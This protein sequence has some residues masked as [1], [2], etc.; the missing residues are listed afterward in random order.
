MKGILQ[1]L[2]RASPTVLTILGA[3][4]VAGTAYLAIKGDRK[5]S[6]LRYNAMD[7]KN[8]ANLEKAKATGQD[9]VEIK[10]LTREEV[11]KLTW[12]CYLPA[13][14]VGL[15]TI[16]CIF[17]AN[18]LTRRQQAAITS[19]YALLDQAYKEYRKKVIELYGPDTDE[20]VRANIAEEKLK[21]VDLEE[22]ADGKRLFYD[23]FSGQYFERTMAEVMDAEYHLNREFILEGSAK[24]ND[25]YELLGLPKT[26]LG[27]VVGWDGESGI[28]FYGYQWIDISHE[29][30][31]MDD[32]LECYVLHME[33]TP[34]E[35]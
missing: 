24:L 10:F 27:D 35:I 30:V 13:A 34:H 29:L 25:F 9:E 12:K 33:F 14:S 31:T 3:A 23:E 17:G 8:R 32:G 19:A 20:R 22:P 6:N 18:G 7:Q 15:A 2:K 26:K 28:A 1:T 5:A 4:G 21:K 11:F 16:L